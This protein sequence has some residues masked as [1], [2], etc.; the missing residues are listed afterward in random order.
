MLRCI[1]D[2][3]RLSRINYT[4]FPQYIEDNSSVTTYLGKLIHIPLLQP[5]NTM[6]PTGIEV[7]DDI[8][9]L[10]GNGPAWKSDAEILQQTAF[11]NK[12]MRRQVALLDISMFFY[13]NQVNWLFICWKQWGTALFTN[14]RI[15]PHVIRRA[16]LHLCRCSYFDTIGSA[17]C[18]TVLGQLL[19]HTT[20]DSDELIKRYVIPV[21]YS[22]LLQS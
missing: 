6:Y 18:T 2:P 15:D 1:Y 19:T 7:S 10:C 20:T 22:C 13:L 3:N 14:S 8:V 16:L 11:Q 4:I 21:L 9:S 17:R 5:P 12:L